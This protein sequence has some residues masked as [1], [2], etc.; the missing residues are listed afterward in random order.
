MCYLERRSGFTA[1]TLH[2]T[3]GTAF[4]IKVFGPKRWIV[5]S[6]GFIIPILRG[7]G[8]KEVVHT[9]HRIKNGQ[10]ADASKFIGI[11]GKF[12]AFFRSC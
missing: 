11:V 4:C 5:R 3:F 8:M 1:C 7:G 2:R 9:G 6:K 10:L 12:G